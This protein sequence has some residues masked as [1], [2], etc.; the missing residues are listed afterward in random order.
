MQLNELKLAPKLGR[1]I[2]FQKLL[3][4]LV[5]GT[6]LGPALKPSLHGED[7][8]TRKSCYAVVAMVV[9]DGK[10]RIRYLNIGWPASVHDESVWSNNMVAHNPVS[11]VEYLQGYS[12]FS[13]QFY[14]V[15]AF[16]KH[17][18][19]AE[20]PK[21]QSGFSTLHETAH[22]KNEQTIGIW[23]TGFHGYAI[24]TRIRNICSM[25]GLIW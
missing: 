5:N 7:Y 6:H 20:L 24:P 21:Q 1:S 8:F 15:P 13:N 23:R 19:Q 14:L 3:E 12:A 9:N 2:Y 25:M 11:P 16:K 22:V 17:G 4:Q 18:N 10:W